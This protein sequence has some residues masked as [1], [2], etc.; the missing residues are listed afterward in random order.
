MNITKT[1]TLRTNQLC[2]QDN[3]R[4][5][6][7][8]IKKRFEKIGQISKQK[9]PATFSYIPITKPNHAL[10]LI[11]TPQVPPPQPTSSTTI[12]SQLQQMQFQQQQQ[13]YQMFELF[14]SRFNSKR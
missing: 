13:Q 1:K 10:N 7:Q 14:M 8:N 12:S 6:L 4:S 9:N 5:L 3:Y 2:I 11:A